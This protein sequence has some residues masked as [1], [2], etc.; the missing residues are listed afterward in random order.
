LPSPRARHLPDVSN[1]LEFHDVSKRYGRNW[2]LARLSVVLPSGGSLLLTG[3]NG[4]GKTTFL[5]L[6]ATVV[7]PT[8][9]SVRLFGQDA[10]AEREALRPRIALLG[11]STFL[12]EDLTARE[13]G[14]LLARLLGRP[15]RE[16]DELLEQLGLGARADQPVRTFSAGMKKRLAIVRLLLKRPALALLDEPFGELDPEGIAEMEGHIRTLSRAGTTVVLA[17]HQ[18]EH[19]QSLCTTRLHLARGRAV[20]A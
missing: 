2:A 3:H 11:H 13:N 5:R 9:G 1:A 18:V 10:V 4:S 15:V 17:T 16:S 7:R 6:L 19:G 20:A 12:Y 14:A 8:S